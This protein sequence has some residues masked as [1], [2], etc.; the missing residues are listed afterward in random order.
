MSREVVYTGDIFR[1]QPRGGISSYFVELLG[2]L[3]RPWRL[4]AGVHQSRALDRLSG[5]IEAAGRV[6]AFPGSTRLRAAANR[7]VDRRLWR[8]AGAI[9]HPTY[10]RHPDTLPGGPPL[11]VTV[12]DMAHER[13]P[14]ILE[15]PPWS[16]A[17][18]AVHKAALCARA[19][20][21]VCVSEATRQDLV[22]LLGVPAARTRVVHHGARTWGGIAAEPVAGVSEP[23][24]LWVGER[25]SYKNFDRTVAAWAGLP[26]AA[27]TALLCVG[28]PPFGRPERRR[29]AELGVADR[30]RHL[31]ASEGQLRWA[32]EHAAA[33]LYTSACEGFGLPLV[34]AMSLGC[35]VVTSSVSAMPEVAG[36]LAHYADPLDPESL[37]GAI[38][39]AL[40]AERSPERRAALAAH[41]GRFSWERCAAA[42]DAVYGEVE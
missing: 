23:F 18:P 39:A 27:G 34:E 21:V 25:H 6:R 31:V 19:D 37:A 17:D 26:E 40:A 38:T 9:L 3:E 24:L 8:H 12:H 10:Y 11:V 5:R 20:L 1:M 7:V 4:L 33:L 14:G 16:T 35:E 32:Y 22:E 2:R 30:V 29:L 15:R 41:A 28:G 42:M 13:F 36:E